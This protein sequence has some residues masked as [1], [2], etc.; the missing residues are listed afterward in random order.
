MFY[1]LDRVLQTRQMSRMHV[2]YSVLCCITSTVD[3]CIHDTTRLRVRLAHHGVAYRVVLADADLPA[4]ARR[5]GALGHAVN[6][7]GE[8]GVA[9]LQ[10]GGAVPDVE[11]VEMGEELDRVVLS[12]R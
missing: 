10:R 5:D 8:A 11:D 6:G 9:L 7:G 3:D 1:R 4:L 12:V 2:G